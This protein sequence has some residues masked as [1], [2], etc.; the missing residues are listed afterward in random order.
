MIEVRPLKPFYGTYVI[1]GA[2]IKYEGLVPFVRRCGW[3]D[4]ATVPGTVML[5]PDVAADLIA[6]GLAE[7]VER[8]ATDA[9]YYLELS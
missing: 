5:P 2:A 9:V 1:N 4:I 3:A 7:P 6:R 8:K